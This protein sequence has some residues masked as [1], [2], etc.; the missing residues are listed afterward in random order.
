MTQLT[1][2]KNNKWKCLSITCTCNVV[3]IYYTEYCTPTH[4]YVANSVIR[5]PSSCYPSILDLY[6]F[7]VCRKQQQ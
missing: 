4:H 2:V 1:A 3:A 6:I 7:N 5:R